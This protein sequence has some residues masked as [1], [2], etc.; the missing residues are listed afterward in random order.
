MSLLSRTML[1]TSQW[2][3]MVQILILLVNNFNNFIRSF[4][5]SES[6]GAIPGARDE[7]SIS[8][9]LVHK[10]RWMKVG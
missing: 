6:C 10:V 5:K 3:C 9:G 2:C 1:I 4:K 7:T 8:Q